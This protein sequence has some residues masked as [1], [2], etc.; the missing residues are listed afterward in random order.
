MP[1]GPGQWLDGETRVVTIVQTLDPISLGEI[2]NRG[3]FPDSI[4]PFNLTRPTD[5]ALF[6]LLLQVK[7]HLEEQAEAAPARVFVDEGYKQNG[8]ALE[9]PTFRETFADGLVCFAKS[10]VIHPIQL[11]DFAAFCMNRTQL[12]LAKEKIS[13]LDQSLLGILSPIVWNYVNIEKRSIS[14]DEWPS[15]PEGG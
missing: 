2:R 9:I 11:A 4:G 8:I 13:V 3:H 7:W 10:S 14:L 1:S 12:L 15:L 5:A 6:F